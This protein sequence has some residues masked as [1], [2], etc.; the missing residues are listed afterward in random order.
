[1]QVCCI[2]CVPYLVGSLLY[3]CR[4][5]PLFPSFP[6]EFSLR[7]TNRVETALSVLDSIPNVYPIRS[8]TVPQTAGYNKD[9]GRVQLVFIFVSKNLR[10][11]YSGRITHF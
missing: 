2:A 9:K 6:S 7:V 4:D 11:T 10:S 5:L 8:Y 3:L 1:M